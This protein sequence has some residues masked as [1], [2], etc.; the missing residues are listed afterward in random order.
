MAR[1]IKALPAKPKDLSP[2]PGPHL[3][4]G[5]QPYKL[6]SDLYMRTMGC[7]CPLHAHK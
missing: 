6:F 1:N 4:E 3:V 5:N 2:I 7:A